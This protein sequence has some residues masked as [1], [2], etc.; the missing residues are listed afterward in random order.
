MFRRII[1]SWK[2]NRDWK[3]QH[4]QAAINF[5]TAAQWEMYQLCQDHRD[6]R[7]HIQCRI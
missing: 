2:R 4:L 1:S 3:R 7:D 5:P 6:R